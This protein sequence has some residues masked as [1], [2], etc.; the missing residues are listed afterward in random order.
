M[1]F[2]NVS[3]RL[4]FHL[5][6]F[7]SLPEGKDAIDSFSRLKAKTLRGSTRC[8]LTLTVCQPVVL[9]LSLVFLFKF[10]IQQTA[11][12]PDCLS[13]PLH[14]LL[15]VLS[16]PYQHLLDDQDVH[17]SGE[18]TCKYHRLPSPWHRYLALWSE[19]RGR[20]SVP[21]LLTSIENTFQPNMRADL[22]PCFFLYSLRQYPTYFQCVTHFVAT[23]HKYKTQLLRFGGC[24]MTFVNWIKSQSWHAHCGQARLQ[25]FTCSTHHFWQGWTDDW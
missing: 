11:K 21:A 13:Y 14:L 18:Y 12:M 22:L 24:N 10:W 2:G 5:W 15:R 9:V 3:K 17:Q 1:Y 19:S 6:N 7:Y 16:A 23:L 25:W 20:G 4:I 8:V